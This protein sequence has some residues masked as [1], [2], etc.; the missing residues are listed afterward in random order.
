MSWYQKFNF[1]KNPL[2]IKPSEEFDLFFD[3]KSLIEDII[4]AINKK[5]KIVLKGTLGTGK[6]SVLKKI[7]KH[8]GGNRKVYYYNAFSAS[9][10]LDFENVVK[11]AGGFLSR[12]FKIKSKEL[13]LFIDEASHLKDENIK[14][15]KEYLKKYFKSVLLVSSELDYELPEELKKEFNKV[16]NLKNFT[17]NDAQN[18]IINRL[19][20]KVYQEIFNEKDIKSIYQK[21]QTPRQFLIKCDGFCHNKYNN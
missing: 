3:D 19:G 2:S 17:L 9:S 20:D 14:E 10:Q 4:K 1:E 6:T 11:K 16:I 13:I 18:I 8:Y 12:I 21:S 7:I 15:L 5:Q